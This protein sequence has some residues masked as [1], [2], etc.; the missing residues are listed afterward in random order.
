MKIVEVHTHMSVQFGTR[1]SE[2]RHFSKLDS[3]KIKGLN[4]ELVPQLGVKITNEED[5]VIVPFVNITSLRIEEKPL[6]VVEPTEQ[7][8]EVLGFSDEEEEESED[9]TNGTEDYRII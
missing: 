6:E 1:K 9:I 4:F 7:D 3:R 5:S 2:H 8:K